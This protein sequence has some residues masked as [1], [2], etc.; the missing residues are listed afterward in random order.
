MPFDI[1]FI[2]DSER[3]LNYKSINN[4]T[5]SV[6]TI[7]SV[8]GLFPNPDNDLASAASKAG[9]IYFAQSF[10]PQPK[11]REK[12][13]LRTADQD[14]RLE[15]MTR[16]KLFREVNPEDYSTIFNFYE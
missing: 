16:K 13:K 5:D 7:E 6:V 8:K 3:E 2:E 12:I 14:E 1:Y 15:A 10:K 4:I 11:K 9:N